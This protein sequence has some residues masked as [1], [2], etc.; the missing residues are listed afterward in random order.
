MSEAPFF[1]YLTKDERDQAVKKL[2]AFLK[3]KEL[4]EFEDNLSYIEKL[5]YVT[6]NMKREILKENDLRDI[7]ICFK[8]CTTSFVK[9]FFDGLSSSLKQ[10][11]LHDLQ[12][13]Y[14]I[15]EVVKTLD[16]FVKYLKRKEGEGSLILDED[17]DKLV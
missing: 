5:I 6:P 3:E 10:E 13:K 14:T 1:G 7:A 12:G 9:K 2:E 15:G 11:I 8:F 4:N 16:D 17:S